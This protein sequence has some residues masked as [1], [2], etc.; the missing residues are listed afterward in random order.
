MRLDQFSRHY[1]DDEVRL[2]LILSAPEPAT[3][4]EGVPTVRH[5]DQVLET[6]L[7]NE[8]WQ[9]NDMLFVDNIACMHGR[10]PFKGDR[11][12]TVGMFNAA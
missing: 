5:I 4:E 9:D 10:A 1:S 6:H 11:L 2:P 12:V 7:V 8:P 3:R